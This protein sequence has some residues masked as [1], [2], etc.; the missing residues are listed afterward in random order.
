MVLEVVPLDSLP[1]CGILSTE[2]FRFT[3][4]GIGLVPVRMIETGVPALVLTLLLSAVGRLLLLNPSTLNSVILAQ[5]FS[6]FPLT[7]TLTNRAVTL[8]GKL[9]CSADRVV[10][11][12]LPVNTFVK[13][14]P[15]F[16]TDITKVFSRRFPLYHATSTLQIVFCAPKSA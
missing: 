10:P 13:L 9:Y 11:L 8:V 2:N 15:S 7:V 4:F 6:V 16:E 14:V 12:L 5:L 1:F 3:S